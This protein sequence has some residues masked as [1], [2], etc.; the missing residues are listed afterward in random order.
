MIV[1]FAEKSIHEYFIIVSL[2]YYSV[3]C[4]WLS[5]HLRAT[6]VDGR[7]VYQRDGRA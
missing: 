7:V 4:E 3:I 2:Q 1:S 5:Y 6:I